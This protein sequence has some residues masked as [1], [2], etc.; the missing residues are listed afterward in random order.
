MRSIK[1]RDCMTPQV[2][3]ISTSMEVVE[4][5][6]I[7]LQHNITAIPVVDDNGLLVGLLS[8]TDCLQGTLMGGYFSQ[9][10]GLVG[11]SMTRE[12]LT[13]SPNDDIITA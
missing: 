10:G 5:I 6:R 13:V 4:A 12:V 7:L 9:E 1:V 3:T 2:I 11:E 8:E